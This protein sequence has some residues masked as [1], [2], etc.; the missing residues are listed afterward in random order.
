MRSRRDEPS[1]GASCGVVGS[2]GD[3]G[4]QGESWSWYD[5]RKEDIVASTD[6]TGFL[7]RLQYKFL[8]LVQVE[9]MGQELV[10]RA[11]TRTCMRCCMHCMP[12]MLLGSEC[13]YACIRPWR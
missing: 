10:E 4:D 9:R 8:L 6:G 2:T 12:G 1:P 3:E 11:C 5:V 13:A 7:V